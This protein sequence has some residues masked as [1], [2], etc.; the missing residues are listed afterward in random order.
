MSALRISLMAVAVLAMSSFFSTAAFA[1]GQSYVALLYGGNEVDGTSTANLGDPDGYGIA[2]INFVG[3][4]R[5]CFTLFVVRIDKPTMA[6]IHFGP[7]GI[8]GPVSI[9][10]TPVP[11]SG[12][13][14]VSSGCLRASKKEIAAI[15]K[16]PDSYYVNVHN[17]KYPSGAIRGQLF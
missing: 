2:T 5:V 14:G 8:A 7:A 6:H 3:R 10:L 12:N 1:T 9:G 17:G 4:N 16:S 13:P 15:K 11:S